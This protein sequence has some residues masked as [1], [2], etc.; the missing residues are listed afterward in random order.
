[1]KELYALTLKIKNKKV[2]INGKKHEESYIQFIDSS[3]HSK[4]KSPRDNFGPVV[5][6]ANNYFV[7]GDNRDNSL[8]SRFWGTIKREEIIGKVG[9]IYFS[10]KKQFPFVRINRIGEKI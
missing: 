1:M 6:S 3:Y 5:I 4:N 8:D 7:M 2:F 9:M 10:R